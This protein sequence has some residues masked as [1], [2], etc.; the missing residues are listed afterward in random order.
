MFVIGPKI[1]P[2]PPLAIG[3]NGKFASTIK[4]G[5]VSAMPPAIGIRGPILGDKTLPDLIGQHIGTSDSLER[6]VVFMRHVKMGMIPTMP[7]N[8]PTTPIG[9]SANIPTSL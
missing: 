4:I 3:K 7:I 1:D 8:L 2:I 9:K 5:Q 6:I